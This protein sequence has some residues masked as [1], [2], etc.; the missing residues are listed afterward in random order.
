MPKPIRNPKSPTRLMTNALIAALL[1]A[2]L[3]VP[4]SDQQIRA[5]ADEFPEDKQLQQRAADD[6]AE[7]GEAEQA[8]VG[9][10][11]CEAPVIRACSRCEKTCTSVATSVIMQNITSVRLST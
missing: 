7:H 5:E 10:E 11:S 6:Q 2:L 4:E 1:A 9:E 8:E 3:L